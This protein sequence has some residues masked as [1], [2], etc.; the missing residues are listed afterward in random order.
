MEVRQKTEELRR[1]K[2]ELNGQK[3]PLVDQS[4]SLRAKIE[5]QKQEVAN[6]DGKES[7]VDFDIKMNDERINQHKFQL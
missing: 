5:S 3:N 7:K 1:A 2:E 4:H 6:V